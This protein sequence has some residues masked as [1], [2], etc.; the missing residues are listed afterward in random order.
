MTHY[1]PVLL[2]TLLAWGQQASELRSRFEIR[3]VAEGS[4]YVGGGREEGLQEG[5]HLTARRIAPGDALLG[6][7]AIGELV[8]TAITAHSALCSIQNAKVELQVG[9]TAQVANADLEAMQVLQQSK[10]ARRHAQVVSFTEGDPLDQELRD[11]VPKPPSPEVNKFRGRISYEFNSLRNDGTPSVYQHGAAVRIDGSRLGGS[12][13]NLTGYWRGRLDTRQS[14]SALSSQPQ[15]IRDLLNRTYHIGVYYANPESKNVT[16]FGRLYVPW[17][18]SLSTIDGGYFGRKIFKRTTAGVFGGS[19]PDPTAWDYKPNRQIG[20]AFLSLELGSFEKMRWSGAAGLA[21]SRVSWK[22]EREYAFTET[23]FAFKNR[24]SVYH[25]LQADH[26]TP[27][28]LGNTDSGAASSRSFLTVRYQPLE[29]LSFDFNHNYFRTIPTFDLLLLGTG[30]LDKFLFDGISA[31]VRLD[32]RRK[33][34][35]YGNLGQSKRND[36]ARGSLNQMYG[37]SVRDFMGTG[38][39]ADARYTAFRGAFGSGW[40]QSVSGSR[41]VGS[42]LRFELMAG[43]QEFRTDLSSAVRGFFVNSNL[44]YFLSRH[45]VLGGGINLFRG[46]QQNYDQT[47]LAIGYRF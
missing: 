11:Y 21:I 14:T 29:W 27:G 25:N 3:Y 46:K 36:D 10:T 20:G 44:D 33:Y 42:H 12:F 26:L 47:F 30:T 40:Y 37:V 38:V 5:M 1:W 18:S 9:D 39:R 31:G 24:V 19:T 8:V 6:P 23:N 41:E 45:Y 43:E 13:W 7:A 35:L 17:A 4:V 22:A 16:G 15:T 2:L 28:R 32:L 34:S